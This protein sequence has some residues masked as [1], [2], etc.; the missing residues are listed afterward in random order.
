MHGGNLVTCMKQLIKSL[1]KFHVGDYIRWPVGVSV[2]TATEHGEVEPLEIQY[3]YGIIVDIAHGTPPY[4][5][6][7]IIYA[8]PGK[9]YNWIV[10]H[11]NDEE[12]EFEMVSRSSRNE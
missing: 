11:V 2:F 5:D 1:Q 8:G 4:T 10:C 7:I 3:A 6:V 9:Q 12:Y